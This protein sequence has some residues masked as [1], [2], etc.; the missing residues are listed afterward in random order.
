MIINWINLIWTIKR[1]KFHSKKIYGKIKF[2]K[3]L[4]NKNNLIFNKIR[5]YKKYFIL[6]LKIKIKFNI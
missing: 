1:S 2:N 3:T 5:K 4:N 6:I